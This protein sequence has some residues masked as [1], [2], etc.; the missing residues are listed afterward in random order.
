MF[1][2]SVFETVLERLR[3]EAEEAE[4]MATANAAAGTA[5]TPPPPFAVFGDGNSSVS[6]SRVAAAYR[7]MAEDQMPARREAAPA[8]PPS[9]SP[10]APPPH[11]PHLLRTTPEEVAAD[12]GLTGKETLA[13]LTE[14]RRTFARDNHPDGVPADL[15]PNATRR[16]TIANMLIDETLRR[17]RTEAAL[18]LRR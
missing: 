1:G 16:M 18:G 10:T 11:P 3:A 17:I 5:G 12:L 6:S 13:E 14:R 4:P 2:R 8:P 9:P 15:R 7:D